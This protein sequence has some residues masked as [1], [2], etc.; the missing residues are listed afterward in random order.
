MLLF[1]IPFG[2]LLL[3]MGHQSRSGALF[4]YF[5]LEDQEIKFLKIICY[6]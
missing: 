3:M 1:T 6:A 5:C 2:G 4:Y